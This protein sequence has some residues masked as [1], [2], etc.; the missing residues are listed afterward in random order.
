[1]PTAAAFHEVTVGN[2]LPTLRRSLDVQLHFGI[3][4][5]PS[6]NLR[7]LRVRVSVFCGYSQYTSV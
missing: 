7:A 1:L 6:R 3:L 4:S 2:K 5:R